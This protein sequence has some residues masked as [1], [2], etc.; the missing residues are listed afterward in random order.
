MGQPEK[1]LEK[2]APGSTPDVVF[3]DALYLA[4]ADALLARARALD[5]AL[6]SAL[7]LGHNTGLQDLALSLP[8]GGGP[9]YQKIEAKFPTCALAV[10]AF[11]IQSWRD[12]TA[13]IGRLEH[14]VYPRE[15]K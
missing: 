5:D 12:L 9:H 7:V 3:E 6:A 2:Q 1:G 15:L 11:D 14:A 4:G 13:G 8:L 10:F